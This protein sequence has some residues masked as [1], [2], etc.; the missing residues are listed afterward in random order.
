MNWVT[1]DKVHVDLAAEQAASRQRVQQQLS[2]PAGPNPQFAGLHSSLPRYSL[3]DGNFVVS[4]KRGRS[5]L[6]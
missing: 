3:G 5:W 1:L 6:R 2:K 4:V